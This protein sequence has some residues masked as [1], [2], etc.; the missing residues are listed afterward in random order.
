M[1]P[2]PNAQAAP[3]DSPS[4]EQAVSTAWFSR[5]RALLIAALILA[6]LWILGLVIL[7]AFS[8]NPVTLNQRQIR[9]SDLIIT[10]R[11]T[12][13]GSST[14]TVTKEWIRGEEL[15]TLTVT[16]LDQTGITPGDEFLIP[17]QRL[18]KGKSQVT[19]T[20]LPNAVPLIYPATP[21]AQTQLQN[22]L[23]SRIP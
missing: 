10:G 22:L 18:P 11:I 1:S 4:Q 17:L 3:N 8:A 13:V 2:E 23:K 7:A 12:S 14:I 20:S 6:G 19:P 15:Q 9:A 21:E 16:N 5:Q